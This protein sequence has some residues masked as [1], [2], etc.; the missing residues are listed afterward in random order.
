M[1]VEKAAGLDVGSD[2]VWDEVE[3]VEVEVGSDRVC[4]WE[5]GR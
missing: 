2:R 5:S 4:A 3:A 1:R